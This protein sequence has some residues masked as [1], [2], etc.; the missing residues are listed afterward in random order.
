MVIVE[1]LDILDLYGIFLL[2]F[3]FF[4]VDFIVKYVLNVYVLNLSWFV[5][6]GGV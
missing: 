5:N 2:V 3:S 1:S 6:E 4:F